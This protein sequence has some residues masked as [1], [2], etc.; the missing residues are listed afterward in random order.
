MSMKEVDVR[1]EDSYLPKS[2]HKTNT[3]RYLNNGASRQFER[4]MVLA[5]VDGV[6]RILIEFG[7]RSVSGCSYIQ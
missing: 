2:E 4:L 6:A 1:L 3:Y 5:L 7:M